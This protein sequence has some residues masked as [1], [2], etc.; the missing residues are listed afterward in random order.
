MVIY[1]R[2]IYKPILIYFI[3]QEKELLFFLEAGFTRHCARTEDAWRGNRSVVSN[4]G[5]I[6][7][8]VKYIAVC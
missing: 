8:F 2:I 3:F 5:A 1:L 7:R 6:L 4:S